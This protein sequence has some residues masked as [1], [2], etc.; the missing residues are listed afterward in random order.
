MTIETDYIEKCIQALEK[1]LILL[2]ESK[3]ESIDYN[4][5]R[6]ACIK[7]FEIVLEQSGKL[8]RKRLKPYFV[9]S[10]VADKLNFKDIFRH[11]VKYG[12]INIE[13]A[14]R[15][16]GYCDNRNTTT[17]DYG[18]E[19][20]EETLKLLPL[21]IEDAKNLVVVIQKHTNDSFER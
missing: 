14:E 16:F 11:A 7:E 9:T 19:F 2:H 6:S 1:A 15:W 4:I 5:Y 13:E 12:L 10:K 18:V 17:H 8:L 3:E 21:F 20:A